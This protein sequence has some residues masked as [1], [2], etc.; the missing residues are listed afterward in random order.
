[1]KQ[2]SLIL[3]IFI[4][5]SCTGSLTEEQRQKVKEDM[6]QHELRK[7]TDSEITAAAFAAGR[8]L[9]AR[10]DKVG[11]DSARIDSI[12]AASSGRMRFIVPGE[13][14]ALAVEQALI[15]AYV[16]SAGADVQDNVQKIRNSDGTQGDSILYSKP[17]VYKRDDGTDVLL[18]VW[19]IWLSRKEL[20]MNMSEK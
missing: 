11:Q 17:V 16:S 18:G 13:A 14:N 20:I 6:A 12:V 2:L 10:V 1:M 3:I 19:N 15:D 4:T 7:V 8:D 5:I 9:I